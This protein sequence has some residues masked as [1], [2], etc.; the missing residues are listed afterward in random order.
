MTTSLSAKNKLKFINWVGPL[1]L[2]TNA[3]YNAWKGIRK[4]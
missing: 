2:P 4:W 1:P 3:M